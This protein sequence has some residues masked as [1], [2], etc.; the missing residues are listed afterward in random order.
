M[1]DLTIKQ[2]ES[3]SQDKNEFSFKTEVFEWL[4]N[5]VLSLIAVILVFTFM[6]R[7]VGVD[8]ISMVP[9]LQNKDRVIISHLFYEPKREDIVVVTQPTEVNEPLIKRIIALEG[10]T[11]DINFSTGEV[12]VDGEVLNEPYINE[13]TTREETC[14]INLPVTVPQGKVFVMGDNRNSSKDSRDSGVGMIDE[15]YILGKVVLRIFPFESFGTV[16]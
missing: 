6:F 11:V 3:E 9:T 1:A 2:N 10:Q 12:F 4:E 16:R 8:G 13:L 5:I 7:I 14:D 15:G